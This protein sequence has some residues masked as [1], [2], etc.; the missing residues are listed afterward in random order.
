[1][2]FVVGDTLFL[3]VVDATLLRDKENVTDAVSED[4]VDFLGRLS[5]DSAAPSGL[6]MAELATQLDLE[7]FEARPSWRS[8][9]AGGLPPHPPAGDDAVHSPWK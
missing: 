7:G 8:L 3:Q 5:A 2:H 6:A 9:Q 1:M 4:A